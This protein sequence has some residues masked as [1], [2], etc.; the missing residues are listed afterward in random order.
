MSGRLRGATPVG[1]SSDFG[2]TPVNKVG[3][4]QGLLFGDRAEESKIKVGAWIEGDYTYRSTGSG[5]TT[6]APFMNRF[7]NEYLMREIGF[8]I[9]RPLDPKQLSWGFNVIYFGGS[10]AAIINPTRGWVTDPN[11]RFNQMFTDIN[12]TAHLPILTEGGVDIKAGR[13]TSVLGPMGGLGWQRW[14]GSLDYGW[15]TLEEGRFTGVTANWHITKQ[16]S[17]YNGFELGW[18]TFYAQIGHD[19]DYITQLVYWLDPEATR[20]K[21]WITVL[22][23]PTSVDS[24]GYTTVV[25][26]GFSTH[27][28]EQFYQVVNAQWGYSLGP[29]NKTVPP[30]Y[31]SRGWTIYTYA[32]YHLTSTID[33]ITRFEYYKDVD[34]GQFAGGFGVPH[35]N[36]FEMSYGFNY[37]P[38]KW[39]EIRPEIRYDHASNPNFGE[40][41][42]FQNQLT[43]ALN[44]LLKF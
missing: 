19:V 3:I 21:T 27:W 32:G 28:T 40:N 29:V 4:F 35:T 44:V 43:I 25:E 9:S 2:P 31:L 17:W 6:A 8:L 37:H 7:G 38:N 26:A 22:T 33:L 39:L 41:H 18:G 10:D 15:F 34:G 20:T 30:G 42:N 1:E 11:T 14:F 5:I 24:S 23:G 12:L 36:Y 16:L 13:Q